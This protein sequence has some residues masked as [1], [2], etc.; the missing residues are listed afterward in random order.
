MARCIRRPTR[1]ISR[2]RVSKTGSSSVDSVGRIELVLLR[3][4]LPFVAELFAPAIFV[5]GRMRATTRAAAARATSTTSTTGTGT[6]DE[7]V[8]NLDLDLYLRQ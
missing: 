5:R 6:S 3:L 1:L 2:S 7:H 4:P 8:L